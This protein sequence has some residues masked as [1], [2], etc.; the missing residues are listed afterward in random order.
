MQYWQH[1]PFCIDVLR[2]IAPARILDVGSPS[3]SWAPLLRQFCPVPAGCAALHIERIL[4]PGPQAPSPEDLAVDHLHEGAPA[5]VLASLAPDYDVALVSGLDAMARDHGLA[6][7]ASSLE[8]SRYTIVLVPLGGGYAAPGHAP[9]AT[10]HPWCLDDF[11][12]LPIVRQWLG[13]DH[14]SRPLACLVL[15]HDDPAD[16]RGGTFGADAA[17]ETHGSTPSGHDAVDRALERVAEV[18]F[19]LDFIKKS[20]TYQLAQSIRRSAP[21]RLSKRLLRGSHDLVE[22]VATGVANTKAKG[23]EVWLLGAH[24]NA[25]EPA[26]PWDYIHRSGDWVERHEPSQPYGKCLIASHGALE[27]PTGA[28]PELVFLSHPWSGVVRVSAQG[29]TEEFDLYSEHGGRI[30]V[31]PFRTPMLVASTTNAP[32]PAAAP[33]VPAAPRPTPRLSDTQQAFVQRCL[34]EKPTAVAVHCPRWLGVTNSTKN[35]FDHLLPVPESPAQEPYHLSDDDLLPYATALIDSGAPTIVFSGGDEA[36]LR[37]MRLVRAKDPKR[38]CI[39]LWHGNYVQFSDDYA[40]R[41]LRLWLDAARAGQVASIATVKEGMEKFF[42]ALGVRSHFVMN[43]IRGAD[44]PATAPAITTPGTH[45]GLWMSGTLWKTPNVMLAAAKL[46]P[47]ARIHTAGGDHRTRELI[48]QFKIPTAFVSP[49]PLAHDELMRRIRQT[50]L[51]LYV[52]FTECCPMIPLESFAQ[53]VPALVGP[54]SHLFEDDDFLAQR[55]VVPYPDRADSIARSIE[56]A[57]ADRDAIV[58]HYARYVLGYNQ[59][60]RRSIDDLL[61]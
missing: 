18:A 5:S 49:Q 51:T 59:R 38:R 36:H 40:F 46:V 7:L 17:Y 11:H 47:N 14:T 42:R 57:L 26:L 52:T 12:A 16:V 55:L 41:T 9:D 58:A 43:Y 45:L 54:T 13:S 28:N 53:G 6:L 44:A 33:A 3:S 8:K 19:E 37:L 27:V 60:A 48:E 34:R 31:N 2:R 32:P 39:L 35:L 22:V 56:L 30:R 25:G 23:S 29:R 21:V 24:L 50:H 1:I 20:K 61:A 4:P 10:L 15:S